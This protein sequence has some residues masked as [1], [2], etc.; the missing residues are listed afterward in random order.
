MF[1]IVVLPVLSF[2]AK[3]ILSKLCN[4][5]VIESKLYVHFLKGI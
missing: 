5:K 1:T 2:P 3:P 4:L